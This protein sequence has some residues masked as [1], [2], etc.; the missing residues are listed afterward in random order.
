M[1]K[2]WLIILSCDPDNRSRSPEAVQIRHVKL[3]K[4][5][6]QK[7]TVSEQHGCMGEAESGPED[8]LPVFQT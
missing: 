1:E 7:E 3:N 4:G 6:I 8:F 2:I 5:I